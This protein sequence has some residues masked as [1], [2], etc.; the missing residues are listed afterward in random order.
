MEKKM[1]GFC[2]LGFGLLILMASMV[3]V[4]A[5]VDC[6]KALATLTPC[7]PFLLGE[8]PDK[9]CTLCCMAVQLVYKMAGSTKDRRELCTCFVKAAHSI[10]VKPERAKEL[11]HDCDISLPFPIV[12]D[13]N[14]SR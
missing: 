5:A 13:I 2:V 7:R 10:G 6:A 9:P 8:G 11:P 3:S 14:C 12:P 4:N 1:R